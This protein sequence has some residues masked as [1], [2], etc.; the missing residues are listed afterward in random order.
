MK[1]RGLIYLILATILFSSMEVA[2]KATN[3]AFNPIQ[4]NFLRFIIAGVVLL[5]MAIGKLKRENHK[6]DLK[7]IKDFALMG[8]FC[9]VVSLSFYIISLLYVPAYE[10]AILFSSNTFFSIILASIFL[11]E[12][13]SKQS[14]LALFI[15]FLGM[16][17]IVDPFTFK[18]SFTGVIL[19][20]ISAFTFSIYSVFSKYLTTG[21]PT[22][23]TVMTCFA[24]IFGSIQL[25]ILMM[26]S[27]IPSVSGFL[28]AHK[29]N[30]LANI[31]YFS[32]I[33][34][35]NLLLFLFI[36]IGVT[37]IGF[38]S[39]FLA[40]DTLSVAMGSIV[41]FVK[42]VLSPIISYF[43]IGEII[44]TKNEIGLAAIMVG[45]VILFIYNMKNIKH[46]SDIEEL[47][48]VILEDI[49]ESAKDM[50]EEIKKD[51]EADIELL[52]DLNNEDRL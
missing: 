20:I 24:F 52:E 44:S 48:D 31:P 41:F 30:V 9:V 40:I 19:C 26:I 2:I 22:G 43:C 39:Y 18:G 4:L 35:D 32:G 14:M 1:K 47:P 15:A 23:G 38:A 10:V 25:F 16:L 45:S 51:V 3:G 13:I 28:I 7:D 46:V 36:S 29:L 11:R 33:T 21:R 37:G 42:P 12:K 50:K 27:H 5:P 8:F 34:S 49:K 6:I 17:I